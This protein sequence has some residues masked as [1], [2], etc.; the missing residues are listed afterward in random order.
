VSVG[1]YPTYGAKTLVIRAMGE[2]EEKVKKV[3]DEIQS[4]S[5]SLPEL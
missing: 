3:L 5:N 1:S 4:Y 2:D